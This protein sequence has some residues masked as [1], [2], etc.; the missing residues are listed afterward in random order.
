MDSASW[1]TPSADAP[2]WALPDDL[3]ARDALAGRDCGWVEQ[4]RP[5][6]RH[7]SAPGDMVLDP[8][9]GFG[10]SL[11]AAHV[12]GRRGIGFEI[13]AHRASL[14]RERLQRHGVDADVRTGSIV[15]AHPGTADLCVTNVPYF[16]CLWTPPAHDGQLYASADYVHYLAGLRGVFHATRRALREDAFVVAMAQNVVISGRRFALAWDLA[17]ILDS[18]FSAHE[19]RVLCYA[20]DA[21]PLAHGRTCSN[22]SHEYA[23]VYPKRR[24]CI[25]VAAT[26]ELLDAMASAGFAF[27]VFG[28][29]RAYVAADPHPAVPLP[30]DADL[31][32]PAEPD[33]LH[34]LLRWLADRG[35]AL[36]LWGEPI[37]PSLD[38]A[39]WRAHHYVRAERHARD[40]TL[41]RLDLCPEE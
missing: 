9:C 2:E 29:F 35:F 24:A 1:F 3:R 27:T 6:I 34:A 5:F 4:M 18:L 15:D 22:R 14:A 39:T 12:E 10:T 26:R 7:L 36:S 8:F 19:E 40:G 13:D 37:A 31:L 20:V 16:G 23:L 38:L 11:L 17:R 32:L 41:V 30:G 25:D 21:E 28:S 33:R